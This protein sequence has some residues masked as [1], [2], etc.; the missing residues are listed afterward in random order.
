MVNTATSLEERMI[1]KQESAASKVSSAAYRNSGANFE[2]S[3]DIKSIVS[4]S[5]LDFEERYRANML[6]QLL[7][8]SSSQA[9]KGGVNSPQSRLASELHK[10]QDM[11]V[12]RKL[13]KSQEGAR[14]V[15][16][17]KDCSKNFEE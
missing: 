4:Q 6:S 3:N 1:A 5:S 2:K 13:I 12:A 16:Y 7:G 8:V 11:S 10:E 14:R 15:R 17:A 9:E